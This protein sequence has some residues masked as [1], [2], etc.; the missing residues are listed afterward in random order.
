MGT[1]RSQYNTQS[2][3]PCKDTTPQSNL[4]PSRPSNERA[5]A[6]KL[7]MLPLRHYVQRP[8]SDYELNNQHT[9]A[10]MQAVVS[11][12]YLYDLTSL[13]DHY[14]NS[15]GWCRQDVTLL[16]SIR[17][18]VYSPHFSCLL[19]ITIALWKRKC[20]EHVSTWYCTARFWPLLQS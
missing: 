17:K 8:M 6:R 1:N 2:A 18:T 7:P 4:S 9:L 11:R 13:A 16:L 3:C 12:G 10:Y 15:I 14:I 20:C 5:L 19:R